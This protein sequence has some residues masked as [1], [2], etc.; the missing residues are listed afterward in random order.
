MIQTEVWLFGYWVREQVVSERYILKNT[1]NCSKCRTRKTT[2]GTVSVQV[3]LINYQ[4]QTRAWS[5]RLQCQHNGHNLIGF[6]VNKDTNS[7]LAMPNQ[8]ARSHRL[9]C[10]HGPLHETINSKPLG[11]ISRASNVNTDKSCKLAM[12]NQWAQSHRL[13]CQHG[14]KLQTINA[15]PIGT[16]S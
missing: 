16:I 9:Q 13:Q 11:M 2:I 7:K 5:H 1:E 10:Q 8:W 15:K 3:K 6:N 12:P 4:Y 14:H